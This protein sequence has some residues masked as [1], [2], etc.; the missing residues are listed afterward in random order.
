MSDATQ[1]TATFKPR[2]WVD[3]GDGTYAPTVAVS[4]A[5]VD[6][7]AGEMALK[8]TTDGDYETVAASQTDQVLGATGAVGDYLSH[9]LVVPASTSPGAVSIKDGSGTAITVFAGGTGSVTSLAPFAIP[10]NMLSASGAWKVT[11]GASVSCIGVGSF[12]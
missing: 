6:I 11:T 5:T 2:K 12:T 10:L 7:Q 4:G 3:L 8:V 1:E 9:L